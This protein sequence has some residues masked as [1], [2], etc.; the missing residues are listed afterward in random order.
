[1]KLTNYEPLSLNIVSNKLFQTDPSLSKE[2]YAFDVWK[3]LLLAKQASEALFIIIGKLLKAIRDEKL[4]K[5]L[6]YTTFNEFLH[7]EEVSFSRAKAYAYITI[8]EYF[9]QELE[10]DEE[11]VAQM[12]ISRLTMM[13]P[14]LKKIGNKEAVV[15]KI[16]EFNSLGH[17]DFVDVVKKSRSKGKPSVYW[18]DEIEKFVVSYHPDITQLITL[19]NY[20]E[21]SKEI[22][23]EATDQEV[24]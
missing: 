9:I 13:I 7:S 5:M 19:R 12:N 8:Y 10:L 1:M 14:I 18:S 11:K 6:D 3:K 23:G 16:Q 21:I 20:E 24:G 22:I 4:Y 17:G 2:D 15:E